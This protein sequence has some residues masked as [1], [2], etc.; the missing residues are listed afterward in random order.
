MS[1]FLALSVLTATAWDAGVGDYLALGPSGLGGY[2]FYTAASGGAPIFRGGHDGAVSNA[3][4]S[5]YFRTS[6]NPPAG[7]VSVSKIKLPI[8]STY[9]RYSYYDQVGVGITDIAC[10]QHGLFN[11]WI[12]VLPPGLFPY[13][14]NPPAGQQDAVERL[15]RI[16]DPRAGLHIPACC[17][18]AP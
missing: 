6:I 17:N 15:L 2:K 3:A 4:F 13:Y 12:E 7:Y 8:S 10:E 1:R 14:K 5:S 9:C 16:S 18:L 11:G